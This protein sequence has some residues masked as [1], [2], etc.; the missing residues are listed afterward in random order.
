MGET[1]RKYELFANVQK[2]WML[3][4]IWN[5][6]EMKIIRSSFKGDEKIICPVLINLGCRNGITDETQ[7][8]K[9]SNDDIAG[10]GKKYYQVSGWRERKIHQQK[11]VQIVRRQQ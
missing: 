2:L 5:D 11:N 8:I 1:H 10:S 4:E 7:K 9:T 3:K 6:E